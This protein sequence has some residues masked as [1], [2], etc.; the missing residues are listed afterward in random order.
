MRA[1]LDFIRLK[2]V[3]EVFET[4]IEMKLGHNHPFHKIIDKND[5][6]NHLI[7]YKFDWLND[8]LTTSGHCQF[9]EDGTFVPSFLDEVG[10]W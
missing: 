2:V 10:T 9:Q 1:Y 4:R 3:G 5:M 6:K 8:G 7:S